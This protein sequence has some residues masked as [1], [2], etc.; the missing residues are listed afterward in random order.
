M[1]SDQERGLVQVGEAT[2]ASGPTA[3]S[4]AR[5]AVSSWIEDR[6]DAQFRQDARVLVS[7]LVTNS[8]RHAGQPAGAPVHVSAAAVDG[9]VR[10]EVKDRGHGP[11]RPR[12]PDRRTG[13]FGLYLVEQIAA[14]WGVDHED[15]T[16]V[17]F[18]IATRAPGA[19]N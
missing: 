16:R 9:V 3:P 14:R 4:L 18:E 15:G 19:Q 8:V 7:E 6:G 10:V 2:I 12:A 1:H 5:T 17:W 11:V 13:G